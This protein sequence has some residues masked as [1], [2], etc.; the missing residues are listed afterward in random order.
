MKGS[1]I[2]GPNLLDGKVLLSGPLG[3]WSL[4]EMGGVMAW[5]RH[6][7]LV[8][9]GGADWLGRRTLVSLA[10]GVTKQLAQHGSCSRW[11]QL[12][13]HGWDSRRL[14]LVQAG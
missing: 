7:E 14:G 2:P 10:A 8:S 9:R 3:S 1:G 11:E 6:R 13:T 12:A 4:R 5:R